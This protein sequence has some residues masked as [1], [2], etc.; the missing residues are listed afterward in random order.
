MTNWFQFHML[1]TG[2]D[3]EGNEAY[4]GIGMIR[5]YT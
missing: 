4:I 2:A 1:Y 5:E 3:S